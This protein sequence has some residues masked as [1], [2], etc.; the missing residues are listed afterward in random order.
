[1]LSVIEIHRKCA[2]AI[3]GSYRP[4]RLV[5]HIARTDIASAA[6]RTRPV[7]LIAR[8][9]SIGA[10]RYRQSHS[11]SGRLMACSTIRLLMFR[12]IKTDIETAQTGEPF[13]ASLGVANRAYWI[14]IVSELLF[15]TSSTWQMAGEFW[16]GRAIVPFMA[17]KTRQTR[18]LR[19]FVL[20]TTVVLGGLFEKGDSFRYL[21]RVRNRNARG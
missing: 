6:L 13:Q 5:T 16:S 4:A 10:G 18:M 11:S 17:K 14:L 15:M 12:V 3:R 19:V 1:M 8:N 21:I 9:V 20:E 2:R 7:T